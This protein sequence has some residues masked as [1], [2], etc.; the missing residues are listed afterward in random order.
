MGEQK[1]KKNQSTPC[2]AHVP[3]LACLNLVFH[4]LTNPPPPLLL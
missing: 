1:K 4:P 3:A 2:R